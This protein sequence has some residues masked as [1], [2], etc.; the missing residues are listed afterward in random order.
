[1][2]NNVNLLTWKS[3]SPRG[4]PFVIPLAAIHQILFFL[5]L[6]SDTEY[7]SRYFAILPLTD[8]I[9]LML[10]FFVINP[11]HQQDKTKREEGRYP[12]SRSPLPAPVTVTLSSILMMMMKVKMKM[13]P[14][15]LEK[16]S[17]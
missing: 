12:L 14:R 13:I 1:M 17:G 11:V 4:E 3:V 16:V 9:I 7:K 10:H 2:Y 15:H 6:H 5:Y 8:M